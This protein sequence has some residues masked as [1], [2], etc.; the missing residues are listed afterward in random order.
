MSAGKECL[1]ETSAI[2]WIADHQRP[3]GAD[4][5]SKFWAPRSARLLNR[6]SSGNYIKRLYFSPDEHWGA[7]QTFCIWRNKFVG[8]EVSEMRRT[9]QLES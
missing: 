6:L 3:E 2:Q 9:R 5:L 8:L 4:R 7:G 1:R